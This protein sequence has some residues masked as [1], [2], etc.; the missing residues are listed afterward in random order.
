MTSYRW[1]FG[2]WKARRRH[3]ERTAALDQVPQEIIFNVIV[4][5]LAVQLA[6]ENVLVWCK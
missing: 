4:V 6:C 3:E 2:N 5:Q 1:Y